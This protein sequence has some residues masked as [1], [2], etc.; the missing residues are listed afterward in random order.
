MSVSPQMIAQLLQTQ[1]SGGSQPM[2]SS[3]NGV[4]A[5]ADL[6]RKVLMIKALQ[7]QGQPNPQV[8]P[9]QLGGP[10]GGLGAAPQ[11]PGNFVPQQQLQLQNPQGPGAQ[12]A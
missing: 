5:G 10:Q 8:A 9:N 11:I 6:L 12:N 4:Q 2:Q 1:N 3:T 7:N